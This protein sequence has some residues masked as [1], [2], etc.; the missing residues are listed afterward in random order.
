MNR[1][2]FRI[3]V[4]VI[5]FIISCSFPLNS[6]SGW[7]ESADNFLNKGDN[8]VGI[9]GETFSVAMNDIYNM[10]TSVGMII[11]VV[12]GLILGIIYMMKSAVD[13]ANVKES[14]FP[15]LIGSGIIFGAF[16]I[17]KIIINVFNI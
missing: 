2:T 17:W 16:G 15:Y 9:Y 6:F 11:S 13:K 14:L 3:I 4:I 5:F 10:L 7:F 12:V 8:S 1:K